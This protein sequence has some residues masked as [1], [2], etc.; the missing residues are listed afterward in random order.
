MSHR[1]KLVGEICGVEKASAPAGPRRFRMKA[2]SGKPIERA[3]GQA[4]FDCAQM[5]IPAKLP[6]LLNHDPNAVVGY[7]D[8]REVTPEG[9]FLAGVLCSTP[10]G[11]RVAKL[12]DEGFPLTASIGIE[13]DDADSIEHISDGESCS[14]NGMNLKGPMRVWRGSHLFETSFVTAGPADR[15]TSAVVL[16]DEE[17][18]VSKE[19]ETAVA[20]AEKATREKLKQ[21]EDS[22]P[23]RPG[24]GTKAFLAGKTLDQAKLEDAELR[25]SDADARAK[26]AEE[27]LAKAPKPADRHPGIGFAGTERE[28]TVED[29]SNLE[30]DERAKEEWK[31]DPMIRECFSS[32]KS[33]AAWYRAEGS[34]KNKYALEA[35]GET[36]RRNTFG[37]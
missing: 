17:R 31:R 20:E 10:E 2:Y 11:D 25:A 19:V 13:C 32:V 24:F 8:T 6:I 37:E 9:V 22:F 16:S 34:L 29:L 28:G 3:Y 33:L 35:A 7:A 12:S 30:P 26:A 4:V 18:D 5:N 27:K 15:S 23:N 14:V 36:L 1:E 21:F